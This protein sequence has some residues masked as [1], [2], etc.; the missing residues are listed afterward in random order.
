MRDWREL[1][2]DNEGKD[3]LHFSLNSEQTR[4]D[5]FGMGKNAIS[6]AFII[7]AC[8]DAIALSQLSLSL[9]EAIA[10]GALCTVSYGMG[11]WSAFAE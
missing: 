9:W 6:A 7:L 5:C 8:V 3:F 10:F 4:T 1:Q 2:G 11:L